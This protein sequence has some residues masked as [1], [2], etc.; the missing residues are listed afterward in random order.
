M[1]VLELCMCSFVLFCFILFLF[2]EILNIKTCL[3]SIIW[4]QCDNLQFDQVL[5]I[6][7][8]LWIKLKTYKE[9]VEIENNMKYR[10]ELEK[11]VEGENLKD[12]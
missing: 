9:K 11:K 6:S 3:V 10:D 5:H 8:W 12:K 4:K 7:L 2:F 1:D